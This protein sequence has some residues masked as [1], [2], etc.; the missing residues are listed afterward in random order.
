MN[1]AFDAVIFDMDGTLTIP[2]LNFD[3]IRQQL[4]LP[5]GDLAEEI[6]KLPVAQQK[7]AWDVIIQHEQQ[8]ELDQALQPGF[9]S[10]YQRLRQQGLT[11]AMVTRN[12]QN[13]ADALC[14]KFALDFDLILTR[15]FEFIKPHP[16]P[17]LHILDKFGLKPQRTLMVGDYIH[18][19]ECGTAAGTKTCFFHNPGTE[20]FSA[21][22]DFTVTRMTQLEAIVFPEQQS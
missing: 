9:M 11:V 21:H 20:D 7:H 1:C 14:R 5:D 10:F 6:P 8:A 13:S 17:I 19:L 15:E 2:T 3:K 12:L 4:N 22:A 16:G 18:D